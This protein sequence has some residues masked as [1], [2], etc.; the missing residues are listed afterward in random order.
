MRFFRNRHSLRADMTDGSAG[1]RQE[2]EASSSQPQAER[3]EGGPDAADEND[4]DADKKTH[5]C[6]QQQRPRQQGVSPS[7]FDITDL[8]DEVDLDGSA[9]LLRRPDRISIVYCSPASQS[10]GD[11]IVKNN[12]T[13]DRNPL[14]MLL[15]GLRF[16]ASPTGT[17]SIESI[18][19]KSNDTQL[20]GTTDNINPCAL[21]EGSN[22]S[23]A[24]FEV[25]DVV[26]YACSIDCSQGGS[27]PNGTG[28]TANAPSK[29]AN[30]K[31]DNVDNIQEALKENKNEKQL[32]ALY[33]MMRESNHGDICTLMCVS[34]TKSLEDPVRI[35]QAMIFNNNDIDIGITFS[36]QENRLCIASISENGLFGSTGCAIKEGHIVVGI[37]N[38]IA[39]TLTPEDATSL[40]NAILSSPGPS[41][42]SI[43]TICKVNKSPTKWDRLRRTAVAA[44]GGTLF[45]SGAVLMV[46]PLHPVGH[47]M[48]LGGIG[49]LASE[50]EAPRKVINSAKERWSERGIWSRGESSSSQGGNES[51]QEGESGKESLAKRG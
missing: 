26:E 6:R 25:G 24:Y 51:C 3:D 15:S 17:V 36:Q 48:A 5:H 41:Q 22:H 44:G 33:T 7:S 19:Q 45:A 21:L 11:S 14:G 1:R 10:Q 50:F 8:L 46:T 12:D 35:C 23:P 31:T 43:T 32:E 49:V 47:A 20:N 28:T 37:D 38:F 2:I 40:I 42:L 16:H 34:T 9:I 27:D 13:S 4:H 39:S 30:T 29:S 18:Q